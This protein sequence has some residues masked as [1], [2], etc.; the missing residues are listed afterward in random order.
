M[1]EIK[2]YGFRWIV[3]LLFI[4]ANIT[5][6]ILWISFASVTSYATVYYDVEEIMIFLLSAIFMIVYIPVTFLSAWLIDKYDFKIGAGIGAVLQGIFGFLRFVAG[7]NFMFV[8][9]FQLGIAFGQP[10]LLNSVTKLSANWFPESE[11]TTATG[12]GLIAGFLGIA[13]GLAVTPFIVEGLTFQIMVLIY[14][15]LALVSAV[16]FIVFAKNRPP[17]PPSS[18]ITTEK[19]MMGEGMKQLFTN[20]YFLVLVLVSFIGLGIF[21]MITTYIEVIFIPRGFS[22]TDAGI[23]G[24]LMLLGGIVGCIIMSGISD[25]YQKRKILL[26]ISLLMATV[27][28]FVISIVRNIILLYTFAFIFGFGLISAFPVA[29]EYAVDVTTPVPEVSSN[30][31]LVMVGQIGGILFILGLEDFKTQQGDYFPALLIE[32]ILLLVCLLLIFFLKEKK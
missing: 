24:G 8:F 6:Q 20:K 25:Q 2:V 10:F 4:F 23:I 15:I 7:P 27:S 32:S 21:N 29:L 11:R 31:I 16:L 1:S 12:L 26:I 9:I 22:S 13:L 5:I 30:G 18:D 28:L 19:V 17:T 14:G 3:L